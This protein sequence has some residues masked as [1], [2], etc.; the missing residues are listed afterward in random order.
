MLACKNSNAPSGMCYGTKAI[1][2][3]LCFTFIQHPMLCPFNLSTQSTLWHPITSSYLI[4]WLIILLFTYTC[5]V[6][7]VWNWFIHMS[8]KFEVPWKP[9]IYLRA[10]KPC[11]A[12]YKWQRIILWTALYSRDGI[13]RVTRKSMR[14]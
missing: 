1:M 14:I 4:V 9:R 5:S 13:W 10:Y 12:K 2:K 11:L 3:W 6:I 8:Y 7:Q